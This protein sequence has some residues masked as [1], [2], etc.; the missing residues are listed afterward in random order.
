[1]DRPYR[2]GGDQS[3]AEASRLWYLRALGLAS[4]NRGEGLLCQR[5]SIT[6]NVP[7]I[8]YGLPPPIRTPSK[9]QC[10]FSLQSS[11]RGWQTTRRNASGLNTSRINQREPLPN[12]CLKSTET[13]PRPLNRPAAKI[14]KILSLTRRRFH[15]PKKETGG[16]CHQ[17]GARVVVGTPI[18]ILPPPLFPDTRG[19]YSGSRSTAGLCDVRGL[20]FNRDGYRRP[21]LA[22]QQCAWL[23]L[24]RQ[25]PLWSK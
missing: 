3:S 12:Q 17:V 15:K 25:Y 2:K 21:P 7:K 20:I 22:P 1:M 4:T 16:I 18:L 6:G 23:F 10:Y 13:R 8:V 19:L 5:R 14:C 9:K 24:D 11:G